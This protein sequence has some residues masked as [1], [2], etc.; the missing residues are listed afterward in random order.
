MLYRHCYIPIPLRVGNCRYRNKE[1]RQVI[2]SKLK[3]E[4]SEEVKDVQNQN[5]KCLLV[6]RQNDK[7]SPGP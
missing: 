7:H 2:I 3:F 5:Q 4:S 6:A 1:N